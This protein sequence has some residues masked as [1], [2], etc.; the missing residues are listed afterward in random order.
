MLE[1]VSSGIGSIDGK[2]I[3]VATSGVSVAGFAGLL[4]RSLMAFAENSLPNREPFNTVMVLWSMKVTP[5]MR[6]F[7]GVTENHINVMLFQLGDEVRFVGRVSNH[8]GDF[9]LGRCNL[10]LF[11][12]P[13]KPAV[14]SGATCELAGRDALNGVAMV[15][16]LSS[17]AKYT[18][19]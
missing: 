4:N 13:F 2:T 1:S 6:R 17:V 11:L 19:P 7:L 16:P 5:Y 10:N 12:S 8:I 15:L 9:A 18:N 14:N 3:G